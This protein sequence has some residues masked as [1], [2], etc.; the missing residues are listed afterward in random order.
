MLGYAYQWLS[1]FGRSVARP[2]A[3][4]AAI[5]FVWGMYFAPCPNFGPC[6]KLGEGL[7][8]S[9]SLIFP[10]LGASRTLKKPDF[11][12]LDLAMAFLEGGLGVMF[13]FLIGLA[14]HNR[15]RI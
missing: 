3:G 6:V 11:V 15:F 10:F 4:L 7:T 5:W 9:A 13:L 1:D 8:K 12:G 14:L 2:V